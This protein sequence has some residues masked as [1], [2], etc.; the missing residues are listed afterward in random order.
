VA[1]RSIRAPWRQTSWVVVILSRSANT[2]RPLSTAG[3]SPRP[4]QHSVDTRHQ[5]VEAERL[6]H[7]VVATYGETGNLVL[8]WRHGRLRNSTGVRMPSAR[9]RR[10]HA[11]CRSHRANMTSRRHQVG[12]PP[13]AWRWPRSPVP[14]TLDGEPLEA[15][16]PPRRSGD[17]RLIRRPQGSGRQRSP[18]NDRRCHGHP[19]V[20]P[21]G[22]GAAPEPGTKSS[23]SLRV[24]LRSDWRGRRPGRRERTARRAPTRSRERRLDQ[25]CHGHLGDSPSTRSTNRIG[26]STTAPPWSRNLA[27]PSRSGSRSPRARTRPGRWHRGP[28]RYTPGTLTSSP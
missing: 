23:R 9:S 5:F 18:S 7:V 15:K 10:P 6:G 28:G 8:G 20:G 11:R 13:W 4:T 2:R 16:A 14:A 27:G 3:P 1:V 22:T 19:R 21:S 17:V 26:T 25:R 12:A 24:V